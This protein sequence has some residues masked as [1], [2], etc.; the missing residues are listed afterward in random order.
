MQNRN[1]VLAAWVSVNSSTDKT[2]VGRPTHIC[3]QNEQCNKTLSDNNSKHRC[4]KQYCD[5]CLT[6]QWNFS[7]SINPT[8]MRVK[9]L[10]GHKFTTFFKY[11]QC[12]EK[13]RDS[14]KSLEV[15][16]DGRMIMTHG[17]IIY[18]VEIHK[19]PN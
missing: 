19:G 14:S 2:Q 7:P 17:R 11:A 15:R 18:S 1:T 10:E 3:L 12:P 16:K 6:T 8:K 13:V 4:R 9:R 5:F